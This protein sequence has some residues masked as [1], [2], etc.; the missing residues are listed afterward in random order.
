MSVCGPTYVLHEHRLNNLIPIISKC[1]FDFDYPV[2][3]M[4]Y[5]NSRVVLLQLGPS[6][7]TTVRQ[8]LLDSEYVYTY[9][10]TYTY[11][12]VQPQ[13]GYE[14]ASIPFQCVVSTLLI[15]KIFWFGYLK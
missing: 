8:K 9:I 3:I 6:N 13:N 11:H 7:N 2:Y 10:Y 5:R 12:C 14:R 1:A 4:L 15:L